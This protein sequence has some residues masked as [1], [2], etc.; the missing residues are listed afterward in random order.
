MEQ[1]G[2]GA[3]RRESGGALLRRTQETGQ[4]GLQ[5]R[6]P[7]PPPLQRWGHISSKNGSRASSDGPRPHTKDAEP[8]CARSEALRGA[9]RAV[10]PLGRWH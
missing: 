7:T 3:V 10:S 2:W 8:A 6:G 9:S 5:T 4:D 1:H